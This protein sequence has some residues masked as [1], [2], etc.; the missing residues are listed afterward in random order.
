MKPKCA[1]LL[2][3]ILLSCQ[4]LKND[5][6]TENNI[7][8]I[9]LDPGHFHAALVQKHRYAD[10]DSTVHVYAPSGKDL[11]LHLK[12]I[13]AFNTRNDEPTNWNE[14]VY[15]GNDYLEKMLDE[16]PGNVVVI[17]GNNQKKTDYI[18]K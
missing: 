16:K 6:L 4:G 13:E 9:T 7:K 17:S 15:T 11:E 12:R 18:L 10:V 14:Q 5:S 3:A 8:L 1:L 2:A